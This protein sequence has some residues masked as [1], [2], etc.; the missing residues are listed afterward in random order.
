MNRSLFLLVILIFCSQ[1]ASAQEF[2]SLWP[3]GKMP[4]TKGMAL[5]DSIFNERYYRIGNP[6][7]YAF[8]PSKQENRGAAV[9]ICPGG[10]YHHYAYMGAM[11]VAKWFNTMGVSAFVLI[12]R[13]PLSSDLVDRSIVPLQDAQRAMKIIRSKATEWGIKPDKIGVM[14]FSAGGHVASSVGVHSEDV[15]AIGDLLDQIAFR[16]DFMLLVSPVITMGEY[17][18]KG[19]RDNLLGSN[20]SKELIDKYS[21]ELQVTDK[22]PPAFIVHAEND[23][24]VNPKNSF[25]FF[26]ALREKNV[27]ASIHIFPFGGHAIGLQ[28][29]PGS[30]KLWKELCEMWLVEK[31]F[32]EE[33]QVPK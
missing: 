17:A 5:T 26:S 12:S 2:I 10:G 28:N 25:L 20:P 15:S 6:G 29:N 1:L 31:G 23:Q 3:Q 24:T 30:T 27:S 13:L 19:G 7:M 18:H 32:V 4:N 9:V 22:T 8:F 14:G 33:N 16:P 11:Q 21:N